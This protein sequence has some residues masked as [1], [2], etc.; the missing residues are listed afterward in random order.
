M[1][2]SRFKQEM[3]THDAGTTR[4]VVEAFK[5]GATAPVLVSPSIITGWDFPYDTCRYQ[6]ITKI[7]FPDSRSVVEKARAKIDKEYGCHI[8]MNNLI[9]T[10]GRGVRAP[11]DYCETF[12]ID[13]HW[14]WFKNK[15]RRFAPRWFQDSWSRHTGVPDVSQMPK[16]ENDGDGALMTSNDDDDDDDDGEVPW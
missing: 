16:P 2:R 4:S 6:I 9:Q 7:G 3:I 1:S 12:I 13:D 14:D 11:D 5:V 8:A 10:A 15:Y